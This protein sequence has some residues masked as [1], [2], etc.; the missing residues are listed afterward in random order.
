MNNIL[1]D[2]P[3]SSAV[4]DP[5]DFGG[6]QDVAKMLQDVVRTV[7]EGIG[8]DEDRLAAIK[9]V[10]AQLKET[11]SRLVRWSNGDPRYCSALNKSTFSD[12]TMIELFG[13]CDHIPV[14]PDGLLLDILYEAK[15]PWF[16]GFDQWNLLTLES[17]LELLCTAR[18]S[19]QMEP[20]NT[21]IN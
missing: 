5:L 19:I 21:L 3:M 9:D 15:E 6:E 10:Y 13:L 14:G 2:L 4:T 17:A 11:R 8:P 18:D 16:L 7:G 1:I 20:E 12:L